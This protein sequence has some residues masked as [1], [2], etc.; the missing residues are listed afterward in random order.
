VVGSGIFLLELIES[1]IR[2]LKA[3]EESYVQAK[4]WK[5]GSGVASPFT[6]SAME[7][8]IQCEACVNRAYSIDAKI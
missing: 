2:V 8:G 1:L 3:E 7:L 5:L 6:S 4:A